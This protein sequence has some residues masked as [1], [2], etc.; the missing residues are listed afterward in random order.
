MRVLA[1]FGHLQLATLSD[2]WLLVYT[3]YVCLA[4]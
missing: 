3:F 1:V 4:R 2:I